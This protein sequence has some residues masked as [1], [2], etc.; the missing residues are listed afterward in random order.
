MHDQS[1]NDPGF[2]LTATNFAAA[3]ALAF[4][5]CSATRAQAEQGAD[6]PKPPVDSN[7]TNPKHA[8]AARRLGIGGRRPND[9]AVRHVLNAMVVNQKERERLV[10][11]SLRHT[12]PIFHGE[13]HFVRC[14]CALT[15]EQQ[16][17]VAQEGETTIREA[18]TEF[19]NRSLDS[20]GQA[21]LRPQEIRGRLQYRFMRVLQTFLTAEG[22][23]RYRTEVQG[24]NASFRQAAIRNLVADL[25]QDLAL[26]EEQ[27][28]QIG[29]SLSEHWN[30][31]W[32]PSLE[33]TPDA[34]DDFPPIADRFI[35]PYLNA[36]QEKSWQAS[37]GAR[38]SIL[39]GVPLDDAVVD[40]P[41]EDDALTWARRAASQREEI[42]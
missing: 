3:F 37:A 22:V 27:R 35:V 25:D 8:D 42:N 19:A 39:Y 33:L 12:R 41:P 2:L 4:A 18:A 26:S 5:L 29:E 30:D 9:P 32:S 16:H 21:L 13:Y 17:Q 7:T 40:Q 23:A 38:R 24:R 20:R 15:K 11:Q 6:P 10:L 14:V 36:A 28:L 34:N 31:Y 1:K